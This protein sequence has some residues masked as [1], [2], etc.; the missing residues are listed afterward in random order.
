[1]SDRDITEDLMAR[2]KRHYIKPSV[3]FPGGVFLHEVG[4]NGYL[5]Q[6]SRC[7]ALYVGF[8]G[9]SGRMLIGHEVKASRSDWL[10]E[11]NKVGKADAW[12]DQCHEWWLVTVPG[13]VLEGELP[14]GWGLMHPGTSK[15]RMK[16]VT[17]AKRHP[18]REPSW[19]A[20]RS[21]ISRMDTLR[22]ENQNDIEGRAYQK[23][24]LNLNTEIE[25]AVADRFRGQPDAE[26]LRLRLHTIE[27]ALGAKIIIEGDRR[28]YRDD[29]YNEHELA[30]VAQLL[31]IYKSLNQA[32]QHLAGRYATSE[33][34]Q[35]QR[36]VDELNEAYTAAVAS[37]PQPMEETA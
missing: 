7:D 5:N 37:L 36:N 23:A 34:R 8:T 29:E 35:L 16:I 22:V 14:A 11:L 24:R 25:H 13:V 21:V 33:L 26:A 19:N 4:W 6:V 20:M 28:W 18:E 15:T 30:D 27:T 2:L 31:K 32:L 9:T 10:S 17:S 1:M 3:P 12:A